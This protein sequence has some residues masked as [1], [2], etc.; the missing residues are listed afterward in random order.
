MGT[1][2]YHQVCYKCYCQQ[3]PEEST[4]E[5]DDDGN[6]WG[7]CKQCHNSLCPECKDSLC[8]DCE[9]DALIALLKEKI[10]QL[11]KK[12]EEKAI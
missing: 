5:S 8:N 10:E 6:E 11:E 12:R 4:S 3:D 1:S 7:E 2:W 9:K